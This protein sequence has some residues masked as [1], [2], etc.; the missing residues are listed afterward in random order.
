MIG[1]VVYFPFLLRLPRK[2]CYS[3]LIAAAL[4]LGGAVGLELVE[5]RHDSLY[6]TETLTLQF[7]V[8]AEEVM[9][10]LGV[11]LFVCTLL[12]YIERQFGVLSVRFGSPTPQSVATSNLQLDLL[13]HRAAAEPVEDQT[14][15]GP[16]T[17]STAA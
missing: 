11:A 9:E 16:P 12:A 8:L 4:F 13:M 2:T 17:S 10:M 6:G 14:H 15:A 3:M 1:L 7:F 5:G